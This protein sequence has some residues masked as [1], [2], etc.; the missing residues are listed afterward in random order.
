MALKPDTTSDEQWIAHLVDELDAAFPIKGQQENIIENPEE[1]TLRK[2]LR[3]MIMMAPIDNIKDDL[4]I[5]EDLGV[6]FTE[7]YQIAKQYGRED[8]MQLLQDYAPKMS[9]KNKR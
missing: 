4:R 9:P 2:K 7:E 1:I 6:D 5:L 3:V 8:V